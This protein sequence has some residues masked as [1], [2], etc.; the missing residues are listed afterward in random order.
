[1]FALLLLELKSVYQERNEHD[2][3][4]ASARA[5]ETENFRKI[6]TSLQTAIE[7]N[8]REF[9][10]I[11]NQQSDQFD[12]TMRETRLVLQSSNQSLN[13]MTGSGSYFY[14][15][16]NQPMDMPNGTILVNAI[17]T[18]VG[19][20]PVHDLF[21]SVSGGWGWHWDHYYGTYFPGEL[22][23]PREGPPLQFKPTDQQPVAFFIGI[24][25]SNGHSEEQIRFEKLN[26]KWISALYVTSPRK[27]LCV[28]AEPG[29][30]PVTDHTAWPNNQWPS[31]ILRRSAATDQPPC[32]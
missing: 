24:N 23:R 27:I 19:K 10:R 6:A 3:D 28:W 18:F 16:P 22:G 13:V 30:P 7:E 9:N 5:Q 8:E 29:F 14:L 11:I 1:M 21:V 4:Q 20:Y 32:K 12:S 31:G 25:G 15:M 17:P 2:R 26:G